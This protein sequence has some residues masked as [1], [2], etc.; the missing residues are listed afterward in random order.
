MT[1]ANW[2][3][4]NVRL[5][6]DGQV[7]LVKTANGTVE[8]RV[9]FRT[10]PEPRWESR[11]FIAELGLYTYWRPLPAERRLAAEARAVPLGA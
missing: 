2:T 5:P 7:V 1:K 11:S 8:H 4:T 9:R 6:A 3:A 10:D